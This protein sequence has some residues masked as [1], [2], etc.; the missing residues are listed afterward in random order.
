M[1]DFYQTYNKLPN[2]EY[3]GDIYFMIGDYQLELKDITYQ[4]DKIAALPF[5]KKIFAQFPELTYIISKTYHIIIVN[6]NEKT[7]R[8]EFMEKN[9][10]YKYRA[11]FKLDQFNFSTFLHTFKKLQNYHPITKGFKD[12]L[13]PTY[14]FSTHRFLDLKYYYIL[15]E[16][17][18]YRDA[19][20][21]L[22]N[23]DY[24]LFG[25]FAHKYSLGGFKKV[26]GKWIVLP[27]GY[28]ESIDSNPDS[29]DEYGSID[30]N[31]PHCNHGYSLPHGYL[32]DI[33]YLHKI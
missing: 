33:I 30:V 12:Y 23:K 8:F 24:V 4:L 5:Y 10:D 20:I 11:D 2:G 21:N 28:C 19:Q 6:L 29:E 27:L 22:Y 32:N 18:D 16:I 1:E 15:E 17:P 14:K 31:I 7:I 3:N 9:I 13:F 25:I 26:E